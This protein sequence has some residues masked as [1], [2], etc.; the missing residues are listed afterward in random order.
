MLLQQQQ[1]GGLNANSKGQINA[2]IVEQILYPSS[3]KKA[4]SGKTGGG[5]AAA[6]NALAQQQRLAQ[7]QLNY[8]SNPSQ[9]MKFANANQTAPNAK[10]KQQTGQ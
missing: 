3:S 6:Y 8:Q 1:L 10:N 9:H 2:G 7:A 4:Q 5:K